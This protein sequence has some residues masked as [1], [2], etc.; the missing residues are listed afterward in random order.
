MGPP[1]QRRQAIPL[2]VRD[3]TILG[4][5]DLGGDDLGGDEGEDEPDSALLAAPGK[6]DGYL[7]P[8]A[9]GKVYHPEK[10]DSRPQGAKKRSTKSKWSDETAS[11][12]PR[13]T[14]P[15]LSDLKTLSRGIYEGDETTYTDK[16]EKLLLEV[17]QE[18]TDWEV[19][20]LV[21]NLEKKNNKQLK[22]NK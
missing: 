5:D 6:R 12:T 3:R 17:N 13:N 18:L 8:G 10:V 16:E 4:G 14:M 22:E 2:L 19:K 21:K 1:R 15:G 20:A 7:T 11:F 9:R